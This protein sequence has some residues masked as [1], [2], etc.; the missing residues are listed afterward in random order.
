MDKNEAIRAHTEWKKGLSA[1][2][3]NPNGSLSPSEVDRADACDLGRWIDGEGEAQFPTDMAFRH[4]RQAHS[5]FH[6]R[7]ADIV[8]RANDGERVSAGAAL[9]S[10]SDC[11]DA[12]SEVVT[13]LMALP[14]SGH[15]V[16]ARRPAMSLR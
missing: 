8:R 14:I 15:N 3:K 9:G 10:H 13:S 6:S 11:A 4:L 5:L 7:A 1:Y 2:L 12:S 16:R